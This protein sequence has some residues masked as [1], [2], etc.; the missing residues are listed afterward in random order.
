MT[1]N[2][3]VSIR[4]VS[5]YF[6][7]F[8]ALE[9]VSLD[10]HAGEIFALLG[11]SGCG[12]STLLRIL[13]GFETPS[14]GEL[15]LDNKD[16]VPLKPNKRPI[17]MVFQSYAVFPHMT[18]EDNVAYGLKMEGVSKSEITSRVNEALEQVHL[19]GLGQRK[20]N[21]LSG[22]QRQRVALA[23]VLVK[24]PRL[25]LLDEP[26]SAL[27]A[28]L[29][30]AMR[31]ELVKLQESV[32]I[33][34]VI[35]TH[36]Q[37]EAMAIADRIA[38][39]NDGKLRQLATPAELYQRPVD[40][41]VADFVG[42]IHCFDVASASIENELIQVTSSTLPPL[43]LP[44]S[45]MSSALHSLPVASSGGVQQ[46][47]QSLGRQPRSQ[48]D[49]IGRLDSASG[50]L[51]LAIRPEHISASLSEPASA[52]VSLLGSIGDIAFQGQH[53]ILEIVIDGKPSLTA[54]VENAEAQALHNAGFG[55]PVWAYW[56][57]S[58]MLLLP[59]N[60]SNGSN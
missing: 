43:S 25:L 50:K 7:K 54:I 28:K 59:E 55:S 37:S 48:T 29:R 22:G 39:L 53:S 8:A 15:L 30:D 41:F 27:D 2:P 58:D 31:L 23:R 10:I 42:K 56:T 57:A 17:N 18:V 6:G 33:T 60:A 3:I 49:A 16:L 14:E 1:D 19:T 24:K 13:S 38:V 34:F 21:Q 4:H 44:P 35:V 32:G 47:Q 12:K 46:T 9:D 40:A 20:P 52:D 11:P 45:V 5:K 26:L 51:V 36:D